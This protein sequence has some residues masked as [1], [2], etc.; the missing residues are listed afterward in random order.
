M[1]MK[2]YPISMMTGKY[3]LK[4]IDP[5]I[6]SPVLVKKLRLK[7]DIEPLKYFAIMSPYPS[8]LALESI[9]RKPVLKN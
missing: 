5:T 2:K 9:S 8:R 3:V 6:M 1:R 4:S 7:S